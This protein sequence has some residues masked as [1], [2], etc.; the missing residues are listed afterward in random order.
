MRTRC[1]P[2]L[3]V[4]SVLAVPLFAWA[5]D[6]LSLSPGPKPTFFTDHTYDND[7]VDGTSLK[8][9]GESDIDTPAKT[10]KDAAALSALDQAQMGSGENPGSPTPTPIPDTD[11]T[12]VDT[13]SA[14][15]SGL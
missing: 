9:A 14:L 5:G 10:A 11:P 3:L 12:P 6:D 4:C 8:G 13:P 7:D 15:P 2:I 1:L